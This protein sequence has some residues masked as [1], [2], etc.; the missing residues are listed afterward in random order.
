MTYEKGVLD[1]KRIEARH[2]PLHKIDEF[3]SKWDQRFTLDNPRFSYRYLKAEAY[4]VTVF[5]FIGGTEDYVAIFHGL[6]IDWLKEGTTCDLDLLGPVWLLDHDGQLGLDATKVEP[7]VGG[8]DHKQDLVLVADV[9]LMQEPQVAI[10]SLVW[11][12]PLD[13]FLRGVT[14]TLHFSFDSTWELLG[15]IHDGEA[16]VIRDIGAVMEDKIANQDVESRTEVVDQVAKDQGCVGGDV[17]NSLRANNQFPIGLTLGDGSVYLRPTRPDIALNIGEISKV[18][19]G[20]CDLGA[21][22]GGWCAGHG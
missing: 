12:Q 2:D 11:L 14:R 16:C 17:P 18:L 8:H 5:K 9:Q 4:F 3:L 21:R 20:P 10:P 7:R 22:S 1:E 15:N 19:F 13:R 6:G